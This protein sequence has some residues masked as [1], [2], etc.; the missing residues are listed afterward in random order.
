M[1]IQNNVNISDPLGAML[2]GSSIEITDRAVSMA[3]ES[4]LNAV[5]NG[6]TRYHTERNTMNSYKG[7]L[8]SDAE[9]IHSLG[10]G[11]ELA[12][13]QIAAGSQR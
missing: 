13:L 1:N 10:E 7:V 4:T 12:D 5:K 6:S 8:Q 9:H 11:L 2:K 3:G